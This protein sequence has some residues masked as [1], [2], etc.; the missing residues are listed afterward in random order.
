MGAKAVTCQHMGRRALL[1]G[2]VLL[3][4]T[5]GF[6]TPARADA[7][8]LESELLSLVNG[9]RSSSKP[10]K[11]HSGLRSVARG[12][13][14]A[15]SSGGSLSHTGVDG[16]MSNAT[17]DPA[18][19][20]GAPDDGYSGAYCENVAWVEGAPDSEVAERIFN[21]WRDSPSHHRCMVD[22]IMNAGGVGMYWDG[23][24]WWATLETFEDETPPGSQIAQPTQAPPPT[25]EPQ[26]PVVAEPDPPISSVRT[27]DP[28][29]APVARV[30]EP[31]ATSEVEADE[32]AAS[33]PTL[34]TSLT[35]IDAP[36]LEDSKEA[37]AQ[38]LFGWP[39]LLAT[40]GIAG[41]LVLA[42]LFVTRRRGSITW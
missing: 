5:W 31:P 25:P 21:G 15:M 12:H 29:Q 9:Y 8:S 16:R 20:N 40:L 28:V 41:S 7:S 3:A 33:V 42:Y 17:P 11:L 14:R 36:P 22:T 34:T 19:S 39:E 6:P 35:P 32:P 18:E 26:V 23:S 37:S 2:F 1:G 24:K 13:S 4:L 10:L 38:K 30:I 27:D